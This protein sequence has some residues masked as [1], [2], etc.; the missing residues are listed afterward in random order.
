ML[1]HTVNLSDFNQTLAYQDVVLKC[2]DGVNKKKLVACIDIQP[3]IDKTTAHYEVYFNDRLVTETPDF[4]IAL[5]AY[6]KILE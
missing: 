2:N 1:N 4:A 6:N 5:E 3:R